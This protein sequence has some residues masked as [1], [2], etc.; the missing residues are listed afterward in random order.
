MSDGYKWIPNADACETCRKLRYKLHPTRPDRPHQRCKC[1]IVSPHA[2]AG[3]CVHREHRVVRTE[4]TS[5]DHEVQ[6]NKLV[7]YYFEFAVR[8]ICRDNSIIEMSIGLEYDA[9]GVDEF[10]RLADENDDFDAAH[11]KLAQDAADRALTEMA[12]LCPY[13]PPVV[14]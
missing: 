9:D 8:G 12:D 3:K 4:L 14:S 13:C 6:D 2:P 7:R 1:T 5:T 11:D 10:R